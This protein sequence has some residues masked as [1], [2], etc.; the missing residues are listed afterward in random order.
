MKKILM[1]IAAIFLFFPSA[2]ADAA[3]TWQQIH[4]HIRT[5]LDNV[6]TI[7][8]SGDAE[9]AKNA[10][11]DIYYGIYE[12][13]GLES[14]VRSG[15]SSKSANLTEYQFYTLKKVIRAGATQDEVKA[16]G[17]KLLDMIRELRRPVGRLGDVPPGI[18]HSAARG[19]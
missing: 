16:E 14:A 3:Q 18:R 15:I 9:G 2:P 4:D 1:L 13:D 11:N 19:H 10:V 7:Y 17:D 6:Y 12:K 5:E 8:Q